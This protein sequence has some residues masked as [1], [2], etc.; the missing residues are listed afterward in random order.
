MPNDWWL[1]YAGCPVQLYRNLNT[2]TMSVRARV[3]KD[4][5]TSWRVVGH[6][7][8]CVLRDVAL[9][10]Q[11]SGRLRTL[12]VRLRQVRLKDGTIVVRESVERN[13]HAWAQGIL[14]GEFAV[15]I[16]TP[17]ELTYNPRK[18]TTFVERGTNQPLLRSDWLVC[19]NNQVSV[20]VDALAGVIQSEP[21]LKK[22][23]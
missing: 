13:V 11:E 7:S 20:S 19:Q 6:L 14:V 4:G 2:G 15:G 16:E 3:E 23:A 8:N 12:K 21:L 18:N 9:I 17:V 22:V 1:K 10:V 5:K